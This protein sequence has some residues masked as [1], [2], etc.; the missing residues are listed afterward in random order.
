MRTPTW[1][2]SAGALLAFLNSTT[3]VYMVDLV[4][5]TLSGGAAI[6]YSAGDM[7]V[8]INGNTYALGPIIK[9]GE[10]NLSVGI[11]VDTL[12]VTFAADASVTINGVPILQFIAAGGLDGARL[13]LERAFTSAPGQPW[14][15]MVALFTGRVSDAQASRYEAPLTVTS[16]AELLNV[17]I[18]RNVYQPGCSNTLFDGTCGLLKSAFAATGT[19]T[20]ATDTLRTAFTTG[21]AQSAAYFALGWA[22]GLTGAN[23]GIGRTIK[24]FA[25]GVI[26][27]VQPWPL[28]V[29]VGDTFTVYPGCDKTQATC[30]TKFANVIRFRGQPYVPA[31]ETVI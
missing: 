30:A 6:R 21:L 23:A 14:V 22:V 13:M 26:G 9:R 15:G 3:Q 10:T 16:D 7:A 17:M 2:V 25:A 20:T 4:T 11:E 27:T 5:V 18:P 1:E 29:A 8:T 24:T 28:A 19:A 31:P 12:D